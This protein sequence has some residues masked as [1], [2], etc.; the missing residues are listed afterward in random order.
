MKTHAEYT[1]LAPEA[2]QILKRRTER[3]RAHKQEPDTEAALAVAEFSVGG[4]RYAF[5][6][7][8]LHAVVPLRLVTPVPTAPSHIIGVLRFQGQLLTAV[9]LATLLGVRG[10]RQD[11]AVFLVVDAGNG[12]RVAVDSEHVPALG[13]VPLRVVEQARADHNQPVQAVAVPGGGLINLI[14]SIRLLAGVRVGASH[15]R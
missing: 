1:Q 13:T 4:D 7:E 5:P 9:S 12:R 14:D 11:P 2:L 15:G 10:W 6:L 3:A 8:Q